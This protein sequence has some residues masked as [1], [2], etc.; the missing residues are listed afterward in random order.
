MQ[1]PNPFSTPVPP[2]AGDPRF[3]L[4]GLDGLRALAVIGV[5]VFHLLSLIHI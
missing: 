3:V 1:N 5:V 2:Q 4:R